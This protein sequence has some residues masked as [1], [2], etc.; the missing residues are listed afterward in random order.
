MQKE[1]IKYIGF[2][3]E[4]INSFEQNE[5]KPKQIESY[6]EVIIILSKLKKSSLH[7]ENKFKS[8]FFNENLENCR[9]YN[10]Q[11]AE[12]KEQISELQESILKNRTQV[13]NQEVVVPVGTKN[14]DHLSQNENKY[15][16]SASQS[17]SN[18]Y[19]PTD[20]ENK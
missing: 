6:E 1:C 9:E 19:S 15:V 3:T 14:L 13:N 12:L 17:K 18:V 4:G 10:I 8:E 2:N 5:K 16:E 7:L 11:I 20:K